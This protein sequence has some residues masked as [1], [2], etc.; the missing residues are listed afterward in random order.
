[1]IKN[2]KLLFFIMYKYVLSP[3]H[4]EGEEP[5]EEILY[6]KQVQNVW[7]QIKSHNRTKS[8]IQL[9]EYNVSKTE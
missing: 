8:I 3:R 7:S 1:M 2:Q 6:E 4:V 5:L 9:T